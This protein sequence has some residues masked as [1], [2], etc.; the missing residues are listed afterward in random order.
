MGRIFGILVA[1]LMSASPAMAQE[2]VEAV[3]AVGTVFGSLGGMSD[4]SSGLL[5]F[6][7]GEEVIWPNGLGLGADLGYIGA[8]TGFGDGFMMLAGGPIYK[9]RTRSSFKP[10]VRG[11]LTVA[12]NGDGA[13]S[14]MHV[15]GGVDKWI[16]ERWGLRLEVRD[17]LHPRYPGFQVVEFTI[18]LTFKQ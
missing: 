11:G 14:L 18:G 13:L 9:F 10:F 5:H 6:G 7:A 2:T 12:F 16:N 4:G 15:G 8:T 3:S 1:V 17:H